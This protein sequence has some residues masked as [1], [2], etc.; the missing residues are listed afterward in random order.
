MTE[1]IPG[2]AEIKMDRTVRDHTS[3][4]LWSDQDR[5]Q[6]DGD[7]QSQWAAIEALLWRRLQHRESLYGT[8]QLSSETVQLTDYKQS[9]VW[10][11]T[12]NSNPC[13]FC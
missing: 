1:A 11:A 4:P 8:K 5:E 7:I 2:Q 12:Q 13:K 6:E 9:A 3:F 10:E